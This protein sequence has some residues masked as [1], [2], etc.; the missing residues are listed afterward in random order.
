MAEWDLSPPQ[1]LTGDNAK[2]K[3]GAVGVYSKSI[4]LEPCG[5]GATAVFM[6]DRGIHRHALFKIAG[7]LSRGPLLESFRRRVV[8][9][10]SGSPCYIHIA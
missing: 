10:I 1:V 2:G 7:K 3:Q 6:V 9:F 5:A 4:V 8:Y